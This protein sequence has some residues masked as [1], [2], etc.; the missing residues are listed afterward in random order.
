MK[1]ILYIILLTILLIPSILYVTDWGNEAALAGKFVTK[2][3]PKL[4]ITNWF[5]GEFQKEYTLY[6]DQNIGFRTF[7]IKNYNQICYSLFSK[8]NADKVVIG[9]KGILF[10]ESYIRSYLGLNLQEESFVKEKLRKTEY[11]SKELKK[12]GKELVVMIA[13]DKASYYSE[14]IPDAWTAQNQKDTIENNYMLYQ[15]L[16]A[17]YDINCIDFNAAFIEAK[18][19]VSTPLFPKSGIHWSNYAAVAAMDSM[20]RFMRT[21]FNI[22][23]PRPVVDSLSVSAI[24]VSPDDDLGDLLNIY[25]NECGKVLKTNFSFDR[26]NTDN[27]SLLTIGDSFYWNLY[28]QGLIKNMFV[29][30]EF[31]YYNHLVYPAS[32]EQEETNVGVSIRDKL[33]EVD[34]VLI[35]ITSGAL[36]NYAFGFVDQT[37]QALSLNKKGYSQV[38]DYF[39]NKIKGD[40]AW[41][42]AINEKAISKG[43]SLSIALEMD[44]KYMMK[45]LGEDDLYNIRVNVFKETIKKDPMW[46]K[47][48]EEKAKKK[49]LTVEQSIELDAKYMVENDGQ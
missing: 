20:G 7:F 29:K 15:R 19:V 26:S 30:S 21:E 2:E 45:D 25:S 35:L 3:K 5:N 34:V 28:Y 8:T 46:L 10:E 14:K 27:V 38:V 44:A 36:D 11:I 33:D 18:G 24:P 39:I 41:L 43:V 12:M 1:K 40:Q 4:S 6:L 32:F 23:L 49:G 17:E 13:P 9:K 37:F 47:A 48:V 16:L 22:K 31:W 42:A